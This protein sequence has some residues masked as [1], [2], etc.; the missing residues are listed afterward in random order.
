MTGQQTHTA[1]AQQ[2]YTLASRTSPI[3][4]HSLPKSMPAP[5]QDKIQN[6]FSYPSKKIKTPDTQAGTTKT[7]KLKNDNGLQ[8]QWTRTTGYN[9]QFGKSTAD[10]VNSTFVL[11]STLVLN[12]NFS[13]S[14]PCLRQAAKTLMK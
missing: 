13:I 14:K 4:D 5:T 8:A 10:V 9:K 7:V 6:I 3:S 2:S 12:L 11:L 1:N